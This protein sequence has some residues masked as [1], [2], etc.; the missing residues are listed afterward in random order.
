M[1]HFFSCISVGKDLKQR[2]LSYCI[3]HK[4]TIP[5]K[6]YSISE[7]ILSEQICLIFSFVHHTPRKMQY[8]CRDRFLEN[9]TCEETWTE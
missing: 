9:I 4:Y 5:L 3:L 8:N 1:K 2:I 6:S 7:V